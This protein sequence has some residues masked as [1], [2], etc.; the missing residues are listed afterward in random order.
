MYFHKPTGPPSPT[1]V[2]RTWTRDGTTNEMGLEA[3]VDNLARN[4]SEGEVEG[5]TDER[6]LAIRNSL[7][8]GRTLRTANATFEIP[9]LGSGGE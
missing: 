6:R 9:G 1:V 5:A 3:A 8:A 7:L 4:Q 2:L